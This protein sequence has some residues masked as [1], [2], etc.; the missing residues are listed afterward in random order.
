MQQCVKMVKLLIGLA[1]CCVANWRRKLLLEYVAFY[2]Q[3]GMRLNSS[4]KLFQKPPLIKQL[5]QT[6]MLPVQSSVTPPMPST[7]SRFR[8]HQNLFTKQLLYRGVFKMVCGNKANWNS[9][10]NFLFDVLLLPSASNA[11]L[12]TVSHWSDWKLHKSGGGDL[13]SFESFFPLRKLFHWNA[14]KYFMHG[15]MVL[16]V[17]LRSFA[18]FQSFVRLFTIIV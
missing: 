7:R 10:C 6:P 9:H 8:C 17:L 4:F 1:I 3:P 13:C 5:L 12:G 18:L 14:C 2:I 11:Y 15:T 16:H